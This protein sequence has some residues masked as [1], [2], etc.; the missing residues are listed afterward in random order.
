MEVRWKHLRLPWI[1]IDRPAVIAKRVNRCLELFIPCRH[2]F[3]NRHG[4][5]STRVTVDDLHPLESGGI[6]GVPHSLD[7]S[8]RGLPSFVPKAEVIHRRFVVVARPAQPG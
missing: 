8:D 7:V 6:E 4:K 3:D 2:G 1:C 5:A